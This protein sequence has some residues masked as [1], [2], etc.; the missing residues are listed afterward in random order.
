M[1]A[2]IQ[3]VS[4]ASVTIDNKQHATIEQGLLILLGITHEDTQEDIDWLV[5]KIIGMRIFSDQEDKMNLSIQDIDGELLVISQFTLF[6]STKK[7]N[8]PSYI[9]AARPEVA[10]PLYEAFLSTLSRKRNK[11]IKSGVFGADMK[12]ALVNDGPVTIIIDSKNRNT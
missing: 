6:A 4:E 11:E 12:V 10:V 3:R 5:N 9:D 2:V 8:R 7:G 1:R